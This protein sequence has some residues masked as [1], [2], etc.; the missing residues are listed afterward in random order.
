[1][2]TGLAAGESVVLLTSPLHNFLVKTK[3]I[4]LPCVLFAMVAI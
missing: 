1:M 2:L 4:K 3:L